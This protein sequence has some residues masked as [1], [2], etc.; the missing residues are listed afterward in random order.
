[1]KYVCNRCVHDDV[2]SALILE[3]GEE[4]VCD[5][6]GAKPKNKRIRSLSIR[7]LSDQIHE[8]I[9][10]EYSDVDSEMI[11]YDNEDREY[12]CDTY[13]TEELLVDQIGLDARAEVISD[14]A[15]ILPDLTWCKKYLRPADLG[16]ALEA[17]W[18]E[19]VDLVKYD[20]R[21]FFSEPATPSTDNDAGSFPDP[22]AF[23]I[24]Y[25][26]DAG[27]PPERI[28]DA[29]GVIVTRAN[30]IRT[31]DSGTV[32]FRA[33]V[34]ASDQ[35]PETAAE[36]GPPPREKASQSNRMSPAGIVMFYG[37]FDAETAIRETFQ[38]DREHAAERVVSV[39]QFRLNRLAKVLDL[40]DLPSPPSFFGNYEMHHG[41]SFLREFNDDF[42]K[43]VARDG[44]EHIEYVP[45]QIVTEY[46]RYRFQL[47]DGSRLD[48]IMYKSSRNGSPACVL[49]FDSR[50]CAGPAGGT[51]EPAIQF[52]QD[53]TKHFL[54]SEL[55]KLV[56]P[57]SK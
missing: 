10:W 27:L 35:H 37:A 26:P 46:F 20:V 52:V 57:A 34:H 6:C 8:R 36:L 47:E 45:T 4:R 38:P 16:A 24:T 31:I 54:G 9:L 30:L 40:T 39:A 55:I 12:I 25:D 32:V 43:P 53:A 44:M 42:T 2:L 3:E 50:D 29:L 5:Y 41:I 11:S 15:E 28:L 56:G 22:E 49:F 1:V 18:K 51:R 17:G 13:T 19:F 33:R 23:G 7:D 14:I 21:Y 48:G